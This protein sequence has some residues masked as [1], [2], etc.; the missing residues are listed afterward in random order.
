M[1][2][3]LTFLL[4]FSTEAQDRLVELSVR[5]TWLSSPSIFSLDD[6]YTNLGYSIE[7]LYF[8]KQKVAVGLYFSSSIDAADIGESYFFENE[9]ELSGGFEFLQYGLVGKLST[10]RSRLFQFYGALR[11]FYSEAVYDFENDFG[12]SIGEKGLAAGLGGG[13][14]LKISRSVG[15]NIVEV[16][17]NKYLSSFEFTKSYYGSS[18]LQVRSGI[19]INLMERK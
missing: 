19:V 14:I 2:T 18:S 4:S 12:F 7:A 17:Y 9:K 1:G 16:N 5:G 6:Y 11:L 3:V 8:L 10:N 13:I 15:F